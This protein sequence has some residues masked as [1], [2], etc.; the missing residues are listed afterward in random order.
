MKDLYRGDINHSIA[1]QYIHWLKSLPTCQ[2][3]LGYDD[4]AK[5]N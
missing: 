2:Q 1:M 5:L 3:H 4:Y